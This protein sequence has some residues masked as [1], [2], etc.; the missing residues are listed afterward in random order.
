MINRE[1]VDHV[2]KAL[3]RK[4]AETPGEVPDYDVLAEAAVVAML[5]LMAQ[6]AVQ[7]LKRDIMEQAE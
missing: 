1:W 2:R 3:I 4:D 5:E 6:Q 7:R